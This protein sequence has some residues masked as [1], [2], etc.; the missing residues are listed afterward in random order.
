MRLYVV[1]LW[2]A[3]LAVLCVSTEAVAHG[4]GQ[5]YVFLRI[6]D[7]AVDGRIE[8]PLTTVNE[9]LGY[10]LDEHGNAVAA[11]IESR[12]AAI[13][14]FVWSKVD[15][16][17]NGKPTT[18][19]ITDVHL[20]DGNVQYAVADFVLDGVDAA[21]R[22]MDIEYGI[23]FDSDVEHRGL[24]VIE[25][26]WQ[27]GTFNNEA[28]VSLIF[29]PTDRQQTLDLSSSSVWRGFTALVK[30]GLHHIW[31]GI[32]H[33]SFILVL[34]IPAVLRREDGRWRAVSSVRDGVVNAAKLVGAFAIAH[35]ITL[36]LAALDIVRLP[37]R[38]V[39]TV[40]AA[41]IGIVA[42]YMLIPLFRNRLWPA[43]FV[44]GLFHGFGFAAVLGEIGISSTFMAISLLGFN[45]GV[46][47]GQLVIVI[48]ALAVLLVVRAMPIYA[49]VLAPAGA[50]LFLL[51]S[52]Y[53]VVERAFEI[54]L[55]GGV[56]VS[57][58]LGL[59]T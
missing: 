37:S 10:D 19:R 16:S 38:L 30:L 35:S 20:W 12:A 55:P 27:T 58:V 52:L 51:I 53:W 1:G 17:V 46:E 18:L 31:I 34:L 21:P 45:V 15:M 47:A 26:N 43:V 57:R 50:V 32:D 49:R 22:S 7:Q 28:N 4:L 6:Y 54:E 24:L 25:H 2:F 48:G 14:R 59:F 33:I 8:I 39:E 29:S 5:S 23:G 9:E 3:A 40:I 41:S 44:L 36:N 56:V 11:D 13:E 42:L